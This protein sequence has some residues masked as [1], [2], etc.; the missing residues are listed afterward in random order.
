M[1]EMRHRVKRSS[2]NNRQLN[3]TMV[4]SSCLHFTQAQCNTRK[5]FDALACMWIQQELP[6]SW[7]NR[8]VG[9]TTRKNQGRLPRFDTTI[10]RYIPRTASRGH[11]YITLGHWNVLSCRDGKGNNV[12]VKKVQSIVNERFRTK[13]DES[14]SSGWFEGHSLHKTFIS[15]VSKSIQPHPVA[16][17][18]Q[19]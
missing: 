14:V 3:M 6:L 8:V 17:G 15:Y 19:Y 2:A 12:E 4:T 16:L 1:R 5:D 10:K 9:S 18:M 7:V 13:V 11:S